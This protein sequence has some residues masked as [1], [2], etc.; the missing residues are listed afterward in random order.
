MRTKCREFIFHN[1]VDS[2]TN[3]AGP[4]ARWSWW[5]W[6][7]RWWR[8]RRAGSST[9][10]WSRTA[11]CAPGSTVQC[12]ELSTQHRSLTT[13]VRQGQLPGRL[14]RP[15]GLL[16]RWRLKL[17]RRWTVT[18][19]HYCNAGCA[20]VVSWGIGCGGYYHPGV[21]TEVSHFVEWIAANMA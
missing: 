11:C 10:S 2:F 9:P 14:R 13:C 5:R 19:Q 20:G 1:F 7:C 12:T 6:M 17:P 8:T 3:Q 21:Y 15:H 4:A 16:Q 18:H